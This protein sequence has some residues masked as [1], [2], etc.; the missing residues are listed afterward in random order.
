MNCYLYWEQNIQF[1]IPGVI[2]YNVIYLQEMI[3]TFNAPVKSVTVDVSYYTQ[4]VVI[5]RYLHSLEIITFRSLNLY[6]KM[7]DNSIQII[8]NEKV[9]G[10]L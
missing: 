9:K 4:L 10:V 1:H 7:H 5:N 8:V 6:F 3:S 2:L